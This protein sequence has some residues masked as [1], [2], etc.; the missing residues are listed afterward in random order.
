MSDYDSDYESDN[1]KEV[2]YKEWLDS[3]K[4]DELVVKVLPGPWCDSPLKTKTKVSDKSDLFNT[5]DLYTKRYN[6]LCISSDIIEAKKQCIKCKGS[7]GSRGF[8]SGCFMC[9]SRNMAE[10]RCNIFKNELTNKK[11]LI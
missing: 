5:N 4:S 10:K 11:I 8:S 7:P 2:S 3:N 6:I 1:R 9:V